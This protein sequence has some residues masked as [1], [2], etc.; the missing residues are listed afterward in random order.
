MSAGASLDRDFGQRIDRV[1]DAAIGEQRIIGGVI[2]VAQRGDM[3]YRRAFGL[4][5]R[6]QGKPMAEDAIFRLSSVTKPI[7]AAAAMALVEAGRIAL[8]DPVT[9]FLPEFRPKLP[10]GK[11]PLITVK[12]LLT[13][14][15]G[16]AYGF[17]QP[18]GNAY[19]RSRVSDGLDQPGLSMAENLARIASLPLSYAPGTRWGYSVAMDVLGEVMA[20]AASAPLPD[21]VDR[22]IA[23]PL[24]MSDSAFVVRDERRLVTPY[25]DGPS[26]PVRMGEHHLVP[27]GDGLISFA[28]ARAFDPASFPSGGTGMNGTAGDVLKLLEAVR[29]GGGPVLRPETTRAMTTDA[30]IG[31]NTTRPGWGWGLGF[32]VLRDPAVAPTPQAAGTWRWGGVYGHSWFVDP[33]AELTV[34]ALTNTAIA[35]MAGDFPDAVRD[36]IYGV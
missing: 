1:V 2:L 9:R 10:D 7:V 21:L 20:K 26:G 33:S 31:I 34:V 19:E 23:Q 35:G 29:T 4:A 8:H 30:I 27:F 12:Q 16:L 32:A 11:E 17:A 25:A 18:T 15:A 24:G 28:P 22:L 14:T 6:E 13:H 3:L 36:A 5:D